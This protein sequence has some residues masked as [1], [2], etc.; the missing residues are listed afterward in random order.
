[1]ETKLTS[2]V[3]L[4]KE[5]LSSRN[6]KQF[7]SYDATGTVTEVCLTDQRIMDSGDRLFWATSC[8]PIRS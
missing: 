8:L 2:T 4:M 1:M 6:T 7:G 3:F 5:H